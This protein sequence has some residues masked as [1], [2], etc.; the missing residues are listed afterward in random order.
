MLESASLNTDRHTEL[1][2]LRRALCI[3]DGFS[4]GV[5]FGPYRRVC[6]WRVGGALNRLV[7]GCL[8]R[9]MKASLRLPSPLL[10]LTFTAILDQA[11]TG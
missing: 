4:P 2:S 3:A 8:T 1:H 7:D 11:S 10:G 5:L 9:V 6:A